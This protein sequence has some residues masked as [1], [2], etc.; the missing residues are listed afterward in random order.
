MSYGVRQVSIAVYLGKDT[1]TDQ[2]QDAILES[3]LQSQGGTAV[4]HP[5]LGDDGVLYAGITQGE[6]PTACKQIYSVTRK[7][8]LSIRIWA[9]YCRSDAPTTEFIALVNAVYDQFKDVP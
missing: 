6:V 9:N 5:A 4:D 7:A 8:A 3:N 2:S 1:A